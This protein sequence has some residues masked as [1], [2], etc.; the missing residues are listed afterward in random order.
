MNQQLK[1]IQTGGMCHAWRS[2]DGNFKH[3]FLKL[4]L[5]CEP[6]P[7]CRVREREL[8]RFVLIA[9]D[10]DATYPKGKKK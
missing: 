4:D 7:R 5:G 10:H 1:P 3:V 6:E 9:E 8:M 2:P